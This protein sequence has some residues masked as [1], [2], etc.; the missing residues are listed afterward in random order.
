V[1]VG[2]AGLGCYSRAAEA[3][4]LALPAAQAP[5]S[6]ACRP[7]PHAAP[8]PGPA[9]P[10]PPAP[11]RTEQAAGHSHPH[12][13]SHSH[14]G[15]HE[16]KPKPGSAE[17]QETRAAARFGIRSFVYARR[18]PF[19]PQRCAA[20]A[21]A[22]WWAVPTWR[23]AAAQQACS[24]ACCPRQRALALACPLPAPCPAPGLCRLKDLVLKWLPVTHNKAI[25]GG[26]L[27]LLPSSCCQCWDNGC[28]C[29]DTDGTP[30]H[31]LAPLRSCPGQPCAE[32]F[33]QP[34]AL[35]QVRRPRR[36]T[37]PSRPCSAPRASCG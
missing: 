37:A 9:R 2:A 20:C 35:P 24:V 18:R 29:P 22:A 12:D 27:G 26:A 30:W 28:R 16:H 7:S 1:Q 3:Q 19:H 25:D 15:H 8:D 32:A 31:A 6:Q 5:H 23:P 36:A 33:L 10:C 34:A 17:T 4:R 21:A 13:H 11:R 14:A